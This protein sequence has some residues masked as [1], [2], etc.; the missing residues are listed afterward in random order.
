MAFAAP[1]LAQMAPTLADAAKAR[2]EA[3]ARALA[4]QKQSQGMGRTIGTIAGTVG[5]SALGLPPAAGGAVGGVVGDQFGRVVG[6]GDP[7]YDNPT[8]T[9]SAVS[10]LVSGASSIKQGLDTQAGE[11][12]YGQFLGGLMEP[13][14]ENADRMMAYAAMPTSL[15]K[16]VEAGD[17]DVFNAWYASGMW[18]GI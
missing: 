11:E 15:A 9:A 5:A 3:E 12:K 17:T 18:R 16:R 6:G 1:W 13:G 10:G 7:G 4:E 2:A 14:A 8:Q